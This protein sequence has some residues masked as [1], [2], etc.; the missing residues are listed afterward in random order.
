MLEYQQKNEGKEFCMSSN[1]PTVGIYTLG[2]KV[3]QYES[4]AIG[5]LFEQ[6]GF[7]V[8]PPTAI[9]D[10]YLINTCTVTAESDRKARNFIRRAIRQNPNAIVLVTGCYSQVA[11][12]QV[13]AIRGVH[14]VC[15]NADKKSVV[16]A[17]VDLLARA[18]RPTD[19]HLHVTPPD[20]SGFE[21][22]TITR[23]D[24]TRAYVKIEDGCENRCAYCII[25]SAR[26]SVRSKP[27]ADVLNEVKILTENGCREVVLTG[28]ETASYGKDLPDCTLADLLEQVDRIPNIGRVRLGSLDPSLMRE[29]FV[30]RIAALPSLAPHFHLSMQSG[31]DSVLARMRRK[32]NTRMALEGIAR[33]RRMIPNVQ[34]TTDMITG[35]PGETDAEFAETLAFVRQ[36]EFLTIHVFPYSRRAGTLADSM[37][38]QVPEPIK[39]ARAAALSALQGDIRKSILDRQTNR[40]TEVLFETY[41]KAVA[42]G[43]TADFIEFA[44]PSPVPLHAETRRVRITGNDGV[45]CMGE[46]LD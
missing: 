25:P 13:A 35:F 31:S 5:E 23:F 30:A 6:K 16:D 44:C 33:L 18:E 37:P 9:N 46:I 22:M 42:C 21:A 28:I 27:A 32:Y 34:I 38:D 43:H 4:E 14:Y 11:P 10:V 3:N 8:T 40:V 45:R 19:A 12:H 15:G 2:C 29:A 41:K 7:R 20:I 1:S 17:A 26:G 39:A 24:R 36:A